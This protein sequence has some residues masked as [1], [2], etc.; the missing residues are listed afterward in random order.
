M[1]LLTPARLHGSVTACNV[2]F[3][4][5]V[6]TSD[7]KRCCEVHD[8]TVIVLSKRR[9]RKLARQVYFEVAFFWLQ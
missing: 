2:L 6:F 3:G 7:K 4:F 8:V 5:A 9:K 1:V